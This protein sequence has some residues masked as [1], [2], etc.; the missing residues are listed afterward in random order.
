MMVE[1]VVGELEHFLGTVR[2]QIAIHAAMNRLAVLVGTRAPGVVPEAAPIAL[3]LEADDLRNVRTFLLRL[4]ERPQLAEAARS[5]AD[6]S[7][8]T[9][10]DPLPRSFR[11]SLSAAA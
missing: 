11:P 8:S 7:N 4:L 1:G 10:H 3:L 5:P 2:P 6:N 9:C